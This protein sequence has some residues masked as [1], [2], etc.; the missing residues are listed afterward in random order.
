MTSHKWVRV[1]GRNTGHGAHGPGAFGW[2]VLVAVV[3][4]GTACGDGGD[5]D[6]AGSTTGWQAP[7]ASVSDS[8]GPVLP[9]LPPRGTIRACLS[10]PSCDERFVVA[11]RGLVGEGV[12][13]NSLAAVRAAAEAAI[14]MAEVD[15]RTTSDGVLV[16]M[17]DVTVDRT[18]DGSG[19]IDAMTFEEVALLRLTGGDPSDPAASRVPVLS[20]VLA[21]A[22]ALGVA[23]YLDVKDASAQALVEAVRAERMM[24]QALFRRGI[25]H[26]VEVREAAP[27][28]WLLP[29]VGSLGEALQARERLGGVTVVELTRPAAAP[30]V[31]AALREAGFSVQQDV[32]VGGDAVWLLRQEPTG[33]DT[34]LD[35][36]VQL[37]QSDLPVELQEHI[38]G[39]ARR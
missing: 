10:D 7:G 1:P 36:G 25:E 21:E 35:S 30:A 9:G 38:V 13:E 37:L 4:A 27:D 26:L 29:P 8:I 12:P 5:P 22:Q 16:L 3:L 17:H 31:V 14:P 19:R 18:T 6:G 28:A 32:M 2:V 39:R 34:F 15:I 33:W 20:D 11:H 24:N 23:L